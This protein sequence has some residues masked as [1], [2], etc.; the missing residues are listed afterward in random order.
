MMVPSMSAA[1]KPRAPLRRLLMRDLL[2][3][4]A[5]ATLALL[6]LTLWGYA[7][8]ADVHART[9][10]RASIA[11]MTDRL[12]ARLAD[13][14]EVA[15]ALG[16]LFTSGAASMDRRDELRG[17]LF[18]LAPPKG[19][20][21]SLGVV[22]ADGSVV[23]IAP[24]GELLRAEECALEGE[25][26]ACNQ[27]DWSRDGATASVGTSLDK[28]VDPRTRPWYRAAIGRADGAWTSP[29]VQEADGPV[30]NRFRITYAR[31]LT[32]RGQTIVAELGISLDELLEEVR[33][34]QPSPACLTFITDAQARPILLPPLGEFKGLEAMPGARPI[35][36]GFLPLAQ[37]VLDA[38][39]HDATVVVEGERHYAVTARF[40]S[41]PGIAWRLT[42]TMPA[43]EVM[44]GPR[45]IALL[46]LALAFAA[47]LVVVWRARTLARRFGEPLRALTESTRRA[48]RGESFEAGETDIAEIA[49]LGERFREASVAIGDRAR[50]EGEL[51]H[52][53]RVATIGTL[54]GGVAHDINNQLAVIIAMLDLVEDSAK[55]G[56]PA[57]ED[58]GTMRSAARS[59]SE[60][61][62]SLL[63]FARRGAK[64]E[65]VDVD[66]NAMVTRVA[67]LVAPSLSSAD[68]GLVQ[69]LAPSLPTV[70]GDPTLLEQVVLNLAVNARDAMPNGGK[71][72]L[73]T[74]RRDDAIFFSV[75][76]TGT[77][78]DPA[79]RERIFEAFYTTKDA[80]KGT[81]LGLAI[82]RG[83][84]TAHHGRIEI[85]SAQGQG[86]TFTVLLPAI[87][88]TSSAQIEIAQ[89]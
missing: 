66:V 76:D 65:K 69:K 29:F 26:T 57:H 1:K 16:R 5:F 9:L 79:L 27:H 75:T 38:A 52:V 31:A 22:G 36:P 86:T 7:R 61:T 18:A 77:G 73:A 72:T 78:I 15:E 59:A 56:A 58:L 32:Q 10:T 51:R 43:R 54:A 30:L 33:G 39:A 14:A 20:F 88:P 46:T 80:T 47:V 83:I 23:D 68:V 17:M 63:A 21:R 55:S 40:E 12:H 24:M 50:L 6:A 34:M 74:G 25:L 70:V 13:H 11:R 87:A 4:V 8:V 53:Q 44:G 28:R 71:L 62:R 37:S 82:S 85:E 41:D 64:V 49:E 48:T 81:G 89:S 60:L 45:R 3:L 42:E 2:A 35:G 84:I 67:R 19:S